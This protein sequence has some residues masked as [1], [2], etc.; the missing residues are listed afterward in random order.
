M[1]GTYGEHSSSHVFFCSRPLGV[2]EVEDELFPRSSS[3]IFCGGLYD[4]FCELLDDEDIEV[5]ATYRNLCL[6]PDQLRVSK[7]KDLKDQEE[8]ALTL[9][10]LPKMQE[11]LPIHMSSQEIR[12]RIF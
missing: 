8:R 12:Q 10:G 4:S 6:N 2:C 1:V 7:P 5:A 3:S 11:R 9:F